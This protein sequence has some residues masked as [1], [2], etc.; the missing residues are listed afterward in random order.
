MGNE[1]GVVVLSLKEYN[2]LS[3]T[4]YLMSTETNRKRMLESIQQLENE[5]VIQYNLDENKS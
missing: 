1:D 4:N 2:A 3:E 5:E